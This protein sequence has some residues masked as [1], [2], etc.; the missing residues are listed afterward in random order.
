VSDLER[1]INL[2]GRAPEE[3]RRLLE[4][5][6][7]AP[8]LT[9]EHQERLDRDLDRAFAEEQRRWERRR[10]LAR[11]GA[12]AA[13]VA[14][15]AGVAQ[16]LRSLK[17]DPI[18]DRPKPTHYSRGPGSAEPRQPPPTLTAEPEDA[19]PKRPPAP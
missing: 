13:A 14:L 18:A 3:V 19:G 5:A 10:V 6:Q 2:K 1:W 9:P 15:A 12:L 16:G 8:G 17:S 11:V 4:A 7:D